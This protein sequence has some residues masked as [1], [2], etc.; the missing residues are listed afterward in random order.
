[1]FRRQSRLSAFFINSSTRGSV[2]KATNSFNL[3]SAKSSNAP[4]CIPLPVF[5]SFLRGRWNFILLYC[6]CLLL[7]E[8]LCDNI[9]LI[10]WCCS[11]F[12]AVVILLTLNVFQT[13]AGYLE[14]L[15]GLLHSLKTMLLQMS[16]LATGSPSGNHGLFHRYNIEA[17]TLHSIKLKSARETFGF[18]DI[19]R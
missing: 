2:T 6:I 11:K 3:Y 9:L 16:H 12:I 19:G 4:L 7:T 18:N 13:D 5:F 8:H 1:M 17:I 14:S 15:D 10:L